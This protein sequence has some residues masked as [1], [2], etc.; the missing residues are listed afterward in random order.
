[1]EGANG[2]GGEL[3]VAA[4]VKEKLIIDT[5]PGIGTCQLPC[6]FFFLC[7]DNEFRSKG[8]IVVKCS[9]F[10]SLSLSLFLSLGL[11]LCVCLF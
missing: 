5:D 4:I 11:S 7:I 2:K 10:I 8:S 3:D 1:M 9:P 6:S